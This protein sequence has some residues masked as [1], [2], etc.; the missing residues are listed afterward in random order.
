ML[1]EGSEPVATFIIFLEISARKIK[2]EDDTIPV[3]LK[4]I[5]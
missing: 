1:S 2:L 4:T 5:I 3:R